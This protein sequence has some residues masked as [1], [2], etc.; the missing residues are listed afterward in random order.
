[1]S[2]HGLLKLTEKVKSYVQDYKIMVFDVAFLEDEVIEKFQSDFKL[3]ARFFKKK[4]LG[5]LAEVMSDREICLK[6]PEETLD[7]LRVFTGDERYID[8]Y[9]NGLKEK[10]EKGESVTMCTV[11]D[12]FLQQGM[13]KGLGQGKLQMLLSLVKEGDLS[14]EKAASKVNMSV[15]EFHAL[16]NENALL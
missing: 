6:H 15:E 10:V 1:M 5:Q 4:R 2:L 7:L 13:E 3:V 11:V 16:I 14:M 12:Y 9:R 8:V